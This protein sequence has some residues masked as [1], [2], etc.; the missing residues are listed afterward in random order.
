MGKNINKTPSRISKSTTTINKKNKDFG[1]IATKKIIEKKRNKGTKPTEKKSRGPIKRIR[2]SQK[3]YSDKSKTVIRKW[4][5]A[6]QCLQ[7]E[8]IPKATQ[9]RKKS[10]QDT[11]AKND[12]TTTQNW[13]NASQNMLIDNLLNKLNKNKQV[14]GKKEEKEKKERDSNK[15]LK[16]KQKKWFDD[17]KQSMKNSM[18]SF[19]DAQKKALDNLEKTIL[20]KMSSKEKEDEFLKEILLILLAQNAFSKDLQNLGQVNVSTVERESYL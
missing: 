16:E 2:I 15:S 6:S 8:N 20:D 1:K 10:L 17:L 14:G 7:S 19:N 12:K 5:K 9:N 18:K 3:E 13:E 4:E 11:Q